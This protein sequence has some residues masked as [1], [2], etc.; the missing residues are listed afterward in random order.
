MVDPDADVRLALVEAAELLREGTTTET[1][2][3]ALSDAERDVRVA[4]ARALVTLGH[5]GAAP[6]LKELVTGKEIRQADLTEKIAIFESYGVLGGAEATAVLNGLL[7]KKGLFGKRAPS[8][9]RASA[10]RA[11]GKAKAPGAQEALSAAQGDSDAVVRTAVRQAIQGA[12]L[13]I[14]QGVEQGVDQ[15]VEQGVDQGDEEGVEEVTE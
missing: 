13:G 5:G 12:E 6:A 11:L 15:G 7:N 8:E 9:I 10:A 3:G 2:I 4:A 1:L 14:E